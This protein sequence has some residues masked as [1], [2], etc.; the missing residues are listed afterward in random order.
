MITV[1]DHIVVTGQSTAWSLVSKLGEGDAGEVYVVHSVSD[2]QR[3]ILKRPTRSS[4][5]ADILRQSSQIQ[6]EG[7]ILGSLKG[8]RVKLH[9]GFLTVPHLLDIAKPEYEDSADFFIVIDRAG[10]FDLDLISRLPAMREEEFRARTESYSAAERYFL[11]YLLETKKQPDYVYL[12]CLEAL[13]AL[14]EEIHHYPVELDGVEKGGILWNDVKPDHIFWDPAAAQCTIIDWGNAQFLEMDSTTRDRMFSVSDDYVQMLEGIGAFLK[15]TTPGLY[16]QLAWP[17]RGLNAAN[18][19]PEAQ[20]IR[21]KIEEELKAYREPLLQLREKENSLLNGSPARI[22]QVRDLQK[23][24][25]KLLGYGEYPDYP[26]ALRLFGQLGQELAR[27]SKMVEFRWLAEQAQNLPAGDGT[28]WRLLYALSG[29]GM[30][31]PPES[32]AAFLR[33]IEEAFQGNWTDI[34]YLLMRETKSSALP[35][36][37]PE[38][39]KMLRVMQLEIDPDTPTPLEGAVRFAKVLEAQLRPLKDIPDTQE[40]ALFD[41]TSGFVGSN[42]KNRLMQGWLNKLAKEILPH[43]QQP[44]PPPPY[45]GLAYRDLLKLAGEI[46]AVYPAAG[47]YLERC[48]Y[49]PSAQ[50]NII[51]DAWERKEFEVMNRALRRLLLWDPERLRVLRVIELMETLAPWLEALADGPLNGEGALTFGTRHEVLAREFRTRIGPAGWLDRILGVLKLLRTGGSAAQAAQTSSETFREMPWLRN[52]V[53]SPMPNPPSVRRTGNGNGSEN[54][55]LERKPKNH[56]AGQFFHGFKETRFGEGGDLVLSEPLDLWKPEAQ[57]SSARVFQ[58]FVRLDDE[59]LRQRAIKIMRPNQVEYALP[60][61][62]EEVRVMRIM[63]QFAGITPIFEFG[64]LRPEPELPPE[65]VLLEPER[66]S[67]QLLRY[68]WENADEYVENLP[69]YVH[70]NWLP[71]LAMEKKNYE[72]NLLLLCD[73]GHNQGMLMPVKLGLLISAQICDILAKA[74]ANQIMYRDHKILHYYWQ[75][76]YNGVFMIDWNVAKLN[77]RPL[78]DAETQFDLVQFGAR[79]LH[80]ILTGRPAPGALPAGPTRPDEIEAASHSYTVQWSYDDKR[81]GEQVKMIIE[82]T[83]TGVYT[84]AKQLRHDLVL[85]YRNIS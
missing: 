55:S 42:E 83:L 35:V 11:A 79:A 20:K 31:Y 47:R 73:A 67:G 82:R 13:V 70:D 2:G 59:Q 27:G 64:F 77:D 75:Q 69:R 38:V 15:R 32:Q 65:R 44:E 48:V 18:A 63:Q 68:G 60:L 43:W 54:Y 45:A 61:F 9:D 66:L 7:R 37:Y 4:F 46:S 1:D 10:G 81:L 62:I 23:V 40:T 17:E 74:H 3:A 85:A 51:L 5:Q 78:T 56:L 16:E 21:V 12:R 6:S 76:V 34:L 53:A 50:I 14:F 72:A 84:Q 30:T 22:G 8:F 33:A 25:A 26:A 39:S 28:T 58:G 49:Q 52:H 41:E 71:Y 29:I 24:H 19:I 36:W 80:H 57:G